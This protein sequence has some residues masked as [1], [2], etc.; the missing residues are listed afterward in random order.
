MVSIG[1]RI[2][3][4]SWWSSFT[5]LNVRRSLDR[6]FVPRRQR[7]GFPAGTKFFEQSFQV[8]AAPSTAGAGTITIG[9]LSGTTRFFHA[10]I[11]DNFSLGHVKAKA[12]FV[13]EIHAVI[14]LPG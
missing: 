13:I 12:K 11:I 8:R 6:V 7:R 1:L 5:L 4:T 3:T 9:Q 2:G 10:N 14:S